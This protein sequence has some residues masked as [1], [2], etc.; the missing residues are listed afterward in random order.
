[1]NAEYF[2]RKGLMTCEREYGTR[3]FKEMFEILDDNMNPIVE[4][5]R[6]PAS[7]DSSFS[8][9]NPQSCHI[10]LPNWMLYQGNPVRFLMDFLAYHGYIF[11]S[12]KRIDICLDFV[13]FD[14][15]DSPDRFVRRYMKGKY[16][17]INQ[18]EITAHG[19]DFWNA[20]QW[21]SLSWGA[22]QS[23]VSTKLYDK[24]LE[25]K[26][27]KNQKPYIKIAWMKAGLIDNPI[28]MGKVNS[29]G[30][31]EEQRVWRL[32]YSMKSSLKGWIDL[33]LQHKKKVK[34]QRVPHSLSL[35]DT[36]EKLWSKF[37]DLTFHYFRFAHL[38][39]KNSGKGVTQF[40]LEAIQHDVERELK[41]KDRCTPKILFKFDEGHN[42]TQPEQAPQSTI[43]HTA[44]EILKSK[45]LQYKALHPMPDIVKAVDVILKEIELNQLTNMTPHRQYKDAR[46]LQI[47]LAKK[48][49]GDNRHVMAILDEVL[50]MMQQDQIF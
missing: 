10:R 30:V 9:L 43:K 33:E 2:H 36:K 35:F 8:G 45:L 16:R 46:A 22:R 29:K 23:M 12:I 4:I 25:L 17:K 28:T 48:L 20:P 1:M 6:N 47:T 39:Y 14:T 21:N 15:G 44:D 11:Q 41:R 3:V 13:K 26:E 32:E 31:E 7:G 24:S 18:S 50:N 27:A 38:E 37:Q 42:F 19:T 5:R 49:A 34:K 40:A